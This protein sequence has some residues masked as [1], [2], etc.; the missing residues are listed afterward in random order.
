MNA[1]I[2]LVAKRETVEGAIAQR[3]YASALVILQGADDAV[4]ESRLLDLTKGVVSIDRE[5]GAGVI[6]V[7]VAAHH[8]GQTGCRIV[9][10]G[11]SLATL[12]VVQCSSQV[13]EKIVRIM[14]VKGASAA[15]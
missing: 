7:V 4:A 2:R 14:Q 1:A 6:C 11:I 3:G 8:A 9:D 12:S 15:I 13:T 5:Q 10:I